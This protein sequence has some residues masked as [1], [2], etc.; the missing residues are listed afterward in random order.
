MRNVA[1]LNALSLGPY[2]Q[3]PLGKGESAF[4]RCLRFAQSL[5]EV[6]QVVVL[7]GAFSDSLAAAISSVNDG[8]VPIRQEP[9][10]ASSLS[11]L[12]PLLKKASAGFDSAFYFYADTPFLD[13]SLAQKVYGLH[14]TYA[15]EYSFAD[16]YPQGLVP[17]LFRVSIMPILELLSA[18]LTAAPVDRAALFTI[19]QKDINGFDIETEISP[20]DYRALRLTLAADCKRNALLL[21]RLMDK[22]AENGADCIKLIE[23]EKA[24]LRTLPAYFRVQVA[25]A[26]P[27]KCSYCPYPALRPDLHASNQL[28]ALADYQAL[29]DKI[30][31]LA[32]DAVIDLSPWGEPSLHP[33][34]VS[35]VSATLAHANFRLVIETSGLGWSEQTLLA[36]KALPGSERIDW[37][38]SLDADNEAL[39][40]SLRGEGFATAWST[41]ERLLSLFPGHFYPQAVR[42]NENETNMEAFYRAWKAKTD[43]VIIQKYDWLSGALP[44]R[45][46]TDLSPLARPDCWH[47]KRDLTIL[48]DGTVPLCQAD[49][50]A[51]NSLGNALREDLA[52]VWERAAEEFKRH[53]QGDPRPLCAQCDEYYTY[54]F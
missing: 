43:T 25:S 30:D 15:A 16:G 33:E 48:V 27:Q 12:V 20:V 44:Q 21:E 26:C 36:I 45:R 39:Y 18:P 8:A 23:S 11:E 4:V 31:A 46:V 54:N 13:L 17:E 6:A 28:M 32:D 38:L 19:I 49:L 1:I 2:A 53:T 3:K 47:L 10:A 29:L 5:P 50:K 35:L 42:M 7:S 24:L 41:A 40:R 37:I 14:Q 34:I 9:G 52:A 51:E 22:G